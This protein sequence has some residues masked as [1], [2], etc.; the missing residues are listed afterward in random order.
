MNF[1][2]VDDVANTG[3]DDLPLITHIADE[4]NRLNIEAFGKE[5]T[6]K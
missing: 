3:G 4:V 6:R 1:I 2:T 5:S